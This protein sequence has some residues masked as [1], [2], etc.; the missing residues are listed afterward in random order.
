MPHDGWEQHQTAWFGFDQ[1][2]RLQPRRQIACL[3]QAQPAGASIVARAQ[4]FG[5]GEIKR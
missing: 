4:R 2:Q 3:T 5:E 1:A